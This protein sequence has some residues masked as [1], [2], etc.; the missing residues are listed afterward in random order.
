MGNLAGSD[1]S[2]WPGEIEP[3]VQNVLPRLKKISFFVST[4][5]F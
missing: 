2:E 4:N 5:F 1:L 3:I